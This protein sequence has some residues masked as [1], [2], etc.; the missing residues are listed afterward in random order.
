MCRFLLFFAKR[1]LI[2]DFLLSSVPYAISLN[3]FGWVEASLGESHGVV[4]Q[5]TLQSTRTGG[6]CDYEFLNEKKTRGRIKLRSNSVYEDFC[7][8]R[9]ECPILAMNWPYFK[10]KKFGSDSENV[11]KESL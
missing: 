8:A 10:I 1:L 9:F 7:R 5:S 4:C 6:S 3:Q 2:A 11:A